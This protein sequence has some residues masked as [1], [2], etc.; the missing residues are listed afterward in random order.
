M[1]DN[2][3][4]K[5]TIDYL[6]N[7]QKLVEIIDNYKDLI[8]NR[9]YIAFFISIFIFILAIALAKAYYKKIKTKWEC[10]KKVIEAETEQRLQEIEQSTIIAK[11]TS[12]EVQK[13]K[14]KQIELE[15]IKTENEIAAE[16]KNK[17]Q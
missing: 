4:I 8:S 17:D 15:L 12:E 7:P 14:K 6:A 1:L 5:I 10:E 9:E 16:K 13:L 3:V 11:A 2:T